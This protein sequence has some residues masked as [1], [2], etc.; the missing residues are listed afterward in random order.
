MNT[1]LVLYLQFLKIGAL[2]F[3]GGY[4]VLP[5]IQQYIVEEEAWIT[6]TEF[7]DLVSIS[8]MTPGPIA[9]NSATFVGSKVAGIPGSVVATLGVATPQLIL[10]ML[11]GYFLFSKE[12]KFR[13]LNL[14]LTGIRP[15][16]VG[17]ILIAALSM[18]K[19]SIFPHELSINTAQPVAGICFVLGLIA[20]GK[21]V[22]LIHLIGV[23]AVLGILL[24]FI[25]G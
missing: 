17:L 20:Y 8:Q 19:N 11:L 13:I 6:M 10:M 15:G 3:G 4:A 16:I 23:G 18:M 22:N 14:L 25:L 7:T 9:M 21:K 12:R 2:A 1:L 5:L 24:T